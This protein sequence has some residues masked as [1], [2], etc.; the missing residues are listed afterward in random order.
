MS[1]STSAN[2]FKI[3]LSHSSKD[4][5]FSAEIYEHLRCIGIPVWF[6]PVEMPPTGVWYTDEEI[7]TKLRQGM[8]ICDSALF[9]VDDYALNS[10][11]V[12]YEIKIANEIVHE[13]PNFKLI[14]IINNYPK[15]PLPDHIQVLGPID[16]NHGYKTALRDMM[17]RLDLIGTGP[18]SIAAIGRAMA[19]GS[20]SL[21][22]GI[23]FQTHL[24]ELDLTN[25]VKGI[26]LEI[27][28]YLAK[29]SYRP[30]IQEITR[31]LEYWCSENTQMETLVEGNQWYSRIP[32]A[33]NFQVIFSCLPTNIVLGQYDNGMT[34]AALMMTL[35]YPESGLDPMTTISILAQY[36]Q[37]GSAYLWVVCRGR[38]YRYS[39]GS[40]TIESRLLSENRLMGASQMVMNLANTS[41]DPTQQMLMQMI[42][43]KMG[44]G[45]IQNEYDE[46]AGS[47]EL[48][49]ISDLL[50]RLVKEEWEFPQT[51]QNSAFW[52]HL[53][54]G[55]VL[56]YEL[57]KE[58]GISPTLS[59]QMNVILKSAG[60][61]II[62]ISGNTSHQIN[63]SFSGLQ[64]SD[65]ADG[66]G[67]SL[68]QLEGLAK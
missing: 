43:N 65:I 18:F 30:S 59:Q 57:S 29:F 46:F 7:E 24:E 41:L 56:I 52:G 26:I 55:G 27:R 48:G 8:D 60:A 54:H 32:I 47:N 6:S 4:R 49:F 16:F 39:M 11:W 20:R 45:M 33:D 58:T 61:R 63:I 9:L 15:T 42:M 50:K 62:T 17:K 1:A 2:P 67:V 25:N 23:D 38:V 66:L 13:R 36:G 51:A 37:D 35:V 21:Q 64:S 31:W 3:F 53:T 40:E 12:N 68:D 10:R 44:Q 22:M 5:G 19:A 34:P 14:P 28:K